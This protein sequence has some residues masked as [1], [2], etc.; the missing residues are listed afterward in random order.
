MPSICSGDIACAEWSNVRR[1]EHFLKLLD[2]ANDALN[3]H[4]V[5]ISNMST[6]TV[7]RKLHWPLFNLWN[8]PIPRISYSLS[9]LTNHE[10]MKREAALIAMIRA[11][12]PDFAR[13]CADGSELV[14]L[15]QDSFAADYQ[16]EE[17]ALLGM[18][19][20]YAGLRGK[21]V[22]MIGRS[23]SGFAEE[24]RRQ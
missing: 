21:E 17:Y 23:P 10:R 3:I 24:E 19:I 15:H 4:S 6:A 14:V 9:T 5:S 2:V 8:S 20:K 1:F 12:L 18:A 22:R 16:D 13:M 7:K 11:K